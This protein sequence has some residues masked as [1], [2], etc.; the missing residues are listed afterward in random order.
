M[1]QVTILLI[2][3]MFFFVKFVFTQTTVNPVVKASSSYMMDFGDYYYY[4]GFDYSLGGGIRIS[5]QYQLS[6]LLQVNYLKNYRDNNYDNFDPFQMLNTSL[7][8]SYRFL[9]KRHIVSPVLE[10]DWGINVWSNAEVLYIN[11]SL[12]I[13]D[14]WDINHYKFRKNSIF[15]K[16]KL[17]LNVNL[18]SV[19]I[20]IGAS[21]NTYFF[22]LQRQ[23]SG[24]FYGFVKGLGFE[25][26]VLYTFPMKKQQA[27]KVV[28]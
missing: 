27:K 7:S 3:L 25:A 12:I 14:N 2:T 24:A 4:N 20:N 13:E 1:K 9:R 21:Y 23:N 6:I 5:N 19:D 18:K 22:H 11:S 16:S 10:L 17:L 15:G 8:T 28:E 26:Q